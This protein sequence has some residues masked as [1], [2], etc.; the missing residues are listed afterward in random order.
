MAT[1][2]TRT[3]NF[4]VSAVI[5]LAFSICGTLKAQ[6]PSQTCN[7]TASI[8]P[9]ARSEGFTE[10]T[11]DIAITCTGGAALQPGS[12]I[13]TMNLTV[14]YNT[15][16][17]SRLL[18]NSTDA[19]LSE[20][21][22]LIDDPQPGAQTVCTT[23]KTGCPATSGTALAQ[24]VYQ[25]FVSGNQVTFF[26][27]PLLPPSAGSNAHTYRIT[28]VRANSTALSGSGGPAAPQVLAQVS[29]SGAITTS[30]TVAVAFVES[31]IVTSSGNAISTSQCSTQTLTPVGILTYSELF[32]SAFKTRVIAKSNIA[33]AGQINNP[34]QNVPG[35]AVTSESGFVL[36]IPGPAS[37]VAG[38]AEYGTRLKAS[39]QNVPLGIRIFVSTTNVIS[40]E[41][42]VTP[43]SPIGGSAANTGSTPFAQLVSIGSTESATDG[44]SGPQGFL[45]AISAMDSTNGVPVAE[46]LISNGAGSGVWEIV[47]TNPNLNESIRFA[48][49]AT[50]A[51]ASSPPLGSATVSLSY[52]ASP[53]LFTAASGASA[54]STLPLP[55][56]IASPF[57]PS[58]ILKIQACSLSISKS[59]TGNFV[60]GQANA[61]YMLV[62]ANPAA[63]PTSAGTVTVTDTVPSGLTLL[64][65][66][67]QGWSC[68]AGSGASQ[69]CTR[70]DPLQ[71]GAIYPPIT[72][73]VKVAPDAVSPVVNNATVT[74]GW[75]GNSAAS[76]ST[77]IGSALT[78]SCTP[79]TGPATVGVSYTAAC[80]ASGGA[81][82]YT[83]SINPGAL[84]AGLKLTPSGATATVGGAPSLSGS[85]SYTVTASDSSIPAQS[86]SQAFTG[87]INPSGP[88]IQSIVNYADG[89]KL[90]CPGGLATI[91][92]ANLG[93]AQTQLGPVSGLTVTIN[94]KAAAV[95]SASAQQVIVQLPVDAGTG[96]ANVV[97]QYQ[98]ANSA[99]FAI[100][101]TPFAPGLLSTGSGNSAV[102][103]FTRA[104]TSTGGLQNPANPGEIITIYAVGL[105]PTNPSVGTGALPA[106][107]AVPT[108]T[109]NPVVT[110]GGQ[111]VAL[112]QAALT[113]TAVGT[114][115]LRIVVSGN[116]T[117]GTYPVTISIGGFTSAAVALPIGV[118]GIALT[119]TGFAFQAVQGGGNPSP[120]TFQILNQSN[121]PIN[122]SLSVSLLQGSSWL[123]VSPSSGS[124]VAGQAATISVGVNPAGLAPG[125]YYGQI[126]VNAPSAANSPQLLTIVLRVLPPTINPGPVVDPIGL[127]F[128]GL[129]NG[130]SP[131]PQTVRI[132]N[133]TNRPS[134]FVAIATVRLSNLDIFA[135]SP[136]SGSVAPN[137]PVNIS[138]QPNLSGL[139]AGVYSGTLTIQFPQDNSSST[140]DLLLI[141]TPAFNIN[142]SAFS[143]LPAADGP[144]VRSALYPLV[145]VLGQ[146]RV[147]ATGWPADIQAIVKDNCGTPIDTGSVSASFSNGD[148][149]L[150]LQPAGRGGV[151][152][153]TWSALHVVDP[154]VTVT[155]T[156]D[157]DGLE[158]IGKTNGTL[159]QNTSVPVLYPNG[160]VS[161]GSFSRSA[162]PS[163]GEIVAIFGAQFA[164]SNQEANGLPLPT[165]MQNAT[166]TIAGKQAYLIFTSPGQINAQLRYDTPIGPGPQIVVTRGGVPSIP[167]PVTT[168]TTQPAIFTKD[169]TG[170]G[171][172]NIFV[173]PEPGV[174]VRA[175]AAN[176]AKAGDVL[177]I[178]CTGLG[179]VTPD[180]AAGF[181]TPSDTLRRT[182]NPVTVT[183]GGVSA[184]VAFAGLT[185]GFTGLYQINTTVPAGVPTGT[186]VP[187]VVTA[188][189][190]SSP[191][192]PPVTMVIQ[193]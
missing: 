9:T 140:V 141:V 52:A 85:Y 128:V 10:L 153:I 187:V 143:K 72:V 179:P 134:A 79:T 18:P 3:R 171:Q 95:L 75:S 162:T 40:G 100:T 69:S 107:T 120:Q 105:G 188:G 89:S 91:F 24:N 38:M 20:V 164:D 103:A 22:L 172:G 169:F 58:P 31:S 70:G 97:L 42:A 184:P 33:Y 34:A 62:V 122:Y 111:Q 27:V 182:I 161:G 148:T 59:H 37:Q 49:Y 191:S 156:A 92:G 177:T 175:D 185:P 32:P 121:Q 159:Q 151:W 14:F 17:T 160:V 116:L 8:A 13:P 157:S 168:A 145:T 130:S 174:Q 129:V 144:C 77:S 61:T 133:L 106:A 193:P 166:V 28:N 80:T 110:I 163:P 149:S 71:P 12:P 183:I 181:P 15:A 67:G 115:L 76:D 126:T 39:F 87:V 139:A 113:T 44:N 189:D 43:P 186:Q 147:T 7:V 84:P 46:I 88:A 63:A 60:Q 173:I 2:V 158:G 98:G 51:G 104:D 124:T 48:V 66:S 5:L 132:T 108:V 6:P 167:Q 19:N 123:L 56:F 4:G 86:G 54:A 21:L 53:P 99:A 68:P 90:L 50:Y 11:G 57:S 192:N 1:S 178:Y 96:P 101:L 165:S 180:A 73:V 30:S 154:A 138:V 55:R 35:V 78:M 102:A 65:L 135:V 131:A 23:P 125:D 137:Q 81:A 93:P 29:L 114:Y 155:I 176:P 190:A 25:G 16:I 45:P 118:S 117:P 47:N 136:A 41:T 26:G 74:G 64:S 127:F 109:T 36:P 146:N 112:Y 150:P 170:S 152:S 94:A 82:P 119:Q 142:T 83:W